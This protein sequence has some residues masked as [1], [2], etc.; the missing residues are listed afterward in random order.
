MC[1]LS[2]TVSIQKMSGNLLY[3]PCTTAQVQS[4]SHIDP[5]LDVLYLFKTS[6][7]GASQSDAIYCQTQDTLSI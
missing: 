5:I 3:A 7:T 2:I 4:V 6:R 1:V